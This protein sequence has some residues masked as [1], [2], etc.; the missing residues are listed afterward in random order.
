MEIHNESTGSKAPKQSKKSRGKIATHVFPALSTFP[1]NFAYSLPSTVV[2]GMVLSVGKPQVGM[3]SGQM[4]N[5][6]L[7]LFKN[8]ELSSSF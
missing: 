3:I 5:L 1:P 2:L 8:R 4:R 7:E 6:Y